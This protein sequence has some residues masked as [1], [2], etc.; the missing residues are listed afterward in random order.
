MKKEVSCINTRILLEYVSKNYAGDV[1][2]AFGNLD[3][4][5][6]NLDNPLA[7]LT[8]PNNWTSTD[9][10]V[11]LFKRAKSML[12]DDMAP[13]KIGKYAIQNASLGY[14][15]KIFIKAFW[16][17]KT[18]IK[19]AQ[20]INDKFNRN[21]KVEIIEIKRN[22][23]IVRLH[24]NSEM[25]PT[26]DLCIYNQAIYAY[27]HTIW[28]GNP[29]NIE[30]K[31]CFFQEGPY[32]EYHLHWS[33]QSNLYGY[34][35][36]FFTSRAMLKDIINEQERNR[37]IIENKYA[38]VNLLNEK[39]NRK[40]KQLLAVQETG[41]AILSL[42]DIGNVLNAIMNI[43][44]N[45]CRIN[46]AIIMLVNEEKNHLE[47]MHGVGFAGDIPDDIKNYSISL[48]RVSNILA[49]VASTGRSEYIPDVKTS[50]LQQKNIILTYGKPTSVYVVPLITRSKVIGIIATD[51]VDD[52]GVPDETRE[53]LEIFAPQIA[54][55]IE[56]ARLY[57]RLQE[58]MIELKRSHALLTRTEKLSFL[59]NIAARL[60]H[61]IKNPMTAIGTFLQMLPHKYDDEKFR[62]D[63][64]KIALEET[65][66]INSLITEMMDLVRKK[67]PSFG[68]NDLHALIERMIL[69]ISPQTKA[70]KI[71]IVNQFDS[72]VGMVWM[73]FE[74]MKEVI[75][76]I[77]SN[78]VEYTPE[79][80]T[81]E[82]LTSKCIMDGEIKGV[83]TEIQD[84]GTGIPKHMID[85][86][87]D[88]YFTT[89]HRSAIHNGAG[90][91][92]FIAY[93]NMQ[94]HKGSIEVKNRDNNKGTV[95]TIT[96]P[97]APP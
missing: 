72:D 47:Y 14:T 52:K 5:L 55:A 62:N 10:I 4:E 42:L 19:Y 93:E 84:N 60:A 38:E 85:K 24:W 20:K 13:Y 68:F 17:S 57:S 67:E 16:S 39:L 23:A 58:Q 59:G 41:K 92:L 12:N 28:G 61:E 18:A 82:I 46:R 90:L 6:D 77:L 40:I 25:G 27:L 94:I 33:I 31:C 56:N 79:N 43:L 86:I 37:E 45:T 54:I 95:F 80:G 89:K 73:D 69:L 87:F 83:Q 9:V 26:K 2:S 36:R 49:R 48:T 3:P 74:K 96:M 21:K 76:N 70:R 64:Y 29:L 44:Y 88:P 91:G 65:N 53:T 34:F 35:S 78:A 15:Q 50:S 1:S 71:K 30:E 66:R 11:K 97:V 32:C 7:F 22:S 81:I 75:L 8:D 63:F 51:S